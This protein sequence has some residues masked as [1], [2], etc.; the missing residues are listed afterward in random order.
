MKLLRSTAETVAVSVVFMMAFL[1]PTPALAQPGPS[2]E[3]ARWLLD[4]DTLVDTIKTHHKDPFAHVSSTE[5]DRRVAAVREEI[6]RLTRDSDRAIRLAGLAAAIGDGHTNLQVYGAL[7]RLPLRWFWF[8]AD[9]RIIAVPAEHKRLL[10]RRVVRIGDVPVEAAAQRV[11]MLVPQHE[12]DMFE[13]NWTQYLLRLPDVLRA[14]GVAT[15]TNT[16]SLTLRDDDGR[17]WDATLPAVPPAADASLVLERPYPEPSLADSRPDDPFWFER[18]PGT[19]LLYFNFSGYPE[20]QTMRGTAEALAAEL[21]TGQVRTLLVDLRRNGGG[22]F[23]AGRLLI[24]LLKPPVAGHAVTVYA[25]IGRE[26]FSAGMTNATDFKRTFGALYL[27]E[28]TGARPN[29]VQENF[30]FVLPHSK[31]KGSVAREYYRFQETDTAGLQPDVP[32]PP[33]W[34]AYVAGRDPVVDWL[35]SRIDAPR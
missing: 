18:V 35:L 21:G 27:G 12:S 15:I 14:T 29:G 1:T 8:G 4:L 31:L 5:F 33:S 9:L 3:S 23:K 34:E 11:A 30:A 26:T 24:E 28:V 19:T 13:H 16:V 22:D 10:G 32:L 25:A 6:P 7:D 2:E 20:R 17:E